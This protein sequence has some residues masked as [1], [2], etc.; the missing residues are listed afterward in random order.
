MDAPGRR[1]NILLVVADQHRADA[2][3]AYGN[4]RI[5]TPNLD[6]LSADG[7]VYEN[8]F[9]PAAICT[10]SRYSLFTGLYPHQHLGLSNRSTPHPS[11]PSFP[12][13]LRDHG[14]RCTTVGKMHCTPTHLD[15]GFS[16]MHL[17]EQDGVGRFD[18]EY[19]G[20]LMKRRSVDY[21]DMQD[22]V[23]LYRDLASPEYHETFG[24]VASELA[25]EEYSTG[26]IARRAEEVLDGWTA[27]GNFTVVSFIKPHH[28]FD[29]P[30]EW[31]RR[32]DGI[33]VEPLP[34]WLD[35]CLE[36]D[37]KKH[38]GY[39]PHTALSRDAVRRVTTYYYALVTQIDHY[40]GR[41]V[42]VLQRNGMYDDAIVIYCSDHGEYLGYHHLLLKNNHLYEPLVR[43]PLIVKQPGRARAGERTRALFSLID[44]APTL[45]G[46][47]GLS[48]AM[49]GS[50]A[51]ERDEGSGPIPIDDPYRRKLAERMGWKNL[52]EIETGREVVFCEDFGGGEYMAHN[53]DHKLLL[54]PDGET[55]MLFDLADDPFEIENRI[56]DPRYREVTRR[57]NDALMRWRLFDAPPQHYVD[58]SAPSV[59]SERDRN[60][61]ARQER[62]AFFDSAFRSENAL[63]DNPAARDG[64]TT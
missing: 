38:E 40:V 36:R 10:P 11:A 12:A 54:T 45:L 21:T 32:Y 34:G 64:Q 26:W 20:D 5:L 50:P 57:L 3:G 48:S 55:S 8:A 16:A 46:A 2:L 63:N 41:F 22:Q 42:D 43:V 23:A 56:D 25:E 7:V 35:E 28:P 9:C 24:A 29:P 31:I 19:H 49:L 1:P 52:F 37:L 6:S 59:E 18:D 33:D 58:E 13:V 51:I 62:R 27:E 53:G 60:R 17:A 4:R 47:A 61:A 39:F 14:Y 44:I 15:L 30:E